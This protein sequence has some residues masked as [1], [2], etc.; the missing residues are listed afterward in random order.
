MRRSIATVSLSGTL[1]EKL[2][3]ASW[4]GF[5][6]VEIFESDLISSPLAPREIRALAQS[7]DLTLDLYQ[8]FRDFEGVD[9]ARLAANIRRAEAKFALMVELG[10]DTML[11]CSN[12]T[13]SAIDD[14]ARAA[15]QLRL[16]AEAAEPYGVRVAYE[17]LAWGRHVATYEHAWKLVAE[18][19]H[20][21]LGLC[22]DSFHILS[23]GDDPAAIR[24]IPGEKLFFLQLADALECAWTCCSGAAITAV[25]P[26][27][28]VST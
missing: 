10:V 27:R 19:D 17:A 1:E 20:P 24:D 5:D 28:A 15:S 3:A 18:A 25:S 2:E 26:D 23:R 4:V 21:L 9:D 6:G 13:E 22:L 16:L 8:P 14:D 12:A 7:L 11:V